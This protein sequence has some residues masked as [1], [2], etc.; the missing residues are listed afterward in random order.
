LHAYSSKIKE[1]REILMPF[2]HSPPPSANPLTLANQHYQQ[3]TL[4]QQAGNFPKAIEMLYQAIQIAPQQVLYYNELATILGQLG[5]NNEA[6]TLYQQSLKITPNNPALL[7][8]LGNLF[9]NTGRLKKSIL[10]YR[11][12][13][14]AAPE[15]TTLQW[16]LALSLIMSGKLKEGWEL[17]EVGLSNPNQ[18]PAKQFPYPTWKGYPLK[19][20][21]IL[22]YAEQGIGDEIMFSSCLTDLLKK[23][24]KQCIVECD[25]R[26]VP[27]FSRSFPEVIFCGKKQSDNET[28]LS[29]YP[30]IDCQ[31][32]IGS[33]PLHFRKK[34]INFPKNSG[35]LTPE[36][37]QYQMW[38][39]RL[40]LL[41]NPVNIGISWR[42]G[43][44]PKQQQQRS[45]SL[46]EWMPILSCPN[47]NFINLQYGECDTEL[48]ALSEQHN[49]TVYDWD[50]ADPL[51]NLDSQAAQIAALDLVI[52][53]DNSTVHMAGAVGTPTW[54]MLSSTA[55]WRW[56]ENSNTTFWYPSLK[57]FRQN[58]THNKAE[59]INEISQQL[60]PF[61]KNLQNKD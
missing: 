4:A 54:V 16:N 26:L 55:N 14:K 46:T 44:S 27:L 11:K 58:H 18:R 5:H 40:N 6:I 8:N 48:T 51:H 23:S 21:S 20:K 59:V 3:A 22:V 25:S 12:A 2:T 50:D 36:H 10:C 39:Q 9:K 33:L 49:I 38:K 24:P 34:L 32:A 1:I 43:K 37:T 47:I 31:V 56:L 15:N 17:Y 61:I 57:L 7:N 30:H 52:S 45:I 29:E 35:Y 28:W 53:V 41:P 42:G 60:M 19:E 13:V